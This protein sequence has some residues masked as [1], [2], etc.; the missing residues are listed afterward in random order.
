MFR[1]GFLSKVLQLSRNFQGIPSLSPLL[2]SIPFTLLLIS[3]PIRVT[4]SGPAV[5]EDKG[6]SELSIL[7]AGDIMQHMPQVESAWNEKLNRYVYDSCFNYVRPIIQSYDLAIANFETTLAGKPYSGYPAFSSPDDLVTA[8]QHAGFSIVGTANNHCCDHGRKGI[9]RTVYILD[10]L[11]LVHLGTYR[12][13][14]EYRAANPMIVRKNG[15]KIALLNYTY[16][17]NGIP[18][19]EGNVVSLI[20][21]D[22]LLCDLKAA[23]DSQPDKV[24]LFMHWGEEYQR[25]PNAF[26]KDIAAF[27]F[28]NGADIIIGSHPHVIEPMEWHK[29]DSLH[30]EQLVVWSLGNYISNQRKRYT[31]GGSMFS[32]TLKKENN[33][34]R[35]S[36]ANYQLCWVYNPITDGKRKYF[37]LPVNRFEKDS[38]FMDAISFAAMKLFAADSRELL[39]E[40]L[41]VPE[42]PW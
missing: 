35:I 1:T 31:D 16:G 8:I 17:T 15:I 12:N 18:V 33:Q 3:K 7:F 32:L 19:P 37:I 14:V 42:L 2:F 21:K 38:V 5:P 36:K 11:G 26:Q 28:T 25:E 13:E 24:I 30:G 27:C 40:N 10:S 23:R 6:S 22:R 29:A 41:A 20:E 34:T 39:K 4:D 9:E